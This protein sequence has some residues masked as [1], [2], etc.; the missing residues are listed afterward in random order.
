MK[1]FYLFLGVLLVPT[2]MIVYVLDRYLARKKREFKE[3]GFSPMNLSWPIFG[4]HPWIGIAFVFIGFAFLI[5]SLF[6]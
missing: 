5:Y 2:G 3:R 1:T 6:L 4:P